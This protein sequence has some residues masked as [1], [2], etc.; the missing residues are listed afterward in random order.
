MAEAFDRGEGDFVTSWKLTGH[1][2]DVM[3]GMLR[4]GEAG[5]PVEMLDLMSAT[6]PGV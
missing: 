5:R 4:S 3:T 1:A 2:L 6:C